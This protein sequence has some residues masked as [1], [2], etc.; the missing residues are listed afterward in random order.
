MF[1]IYPTGVP[2]KVTL[3]QGPQSSRRDIP[4]GTQATDGIRKFRWGHIAGAKYHPGRVVVQS[5][6]QKEIGTAYFASCRRQDGTR[7]HGA[8]GDIDVTLTSAILMSANRYVDGT[9]D[10]VSGVGKGHS[11]GIDSYAGP[12]VSGKRT[13][14]RLKSP[15][16]A[17]LSTNTQAV[18]S[19]NPYYG[20][21]L[22]GAVLTLNAGV[23]QPM[24]AC[25]GSDGAIGDASGY[26][27]LQ[28]TGN[29]VAYA[30]AVLVAGRLLTVGLSGCVTHALSTNTS[31]VALA[32]MVVARAHQART[33]VETY[34]ACE[35]LIEK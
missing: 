18:L 22:G 2:A 29:G 23:L 9:M 10:I 3:D 25:T 16:A 1:Q 17:R 26:Q 28:V 30:S 5:T 14:V 11:Y 34:V 32:K 4:L 33:I 8:V 21:H 31:S 35:W 24:G 19:P 13:L 15:L 27:W 20:L 7:T 6:T 12:G